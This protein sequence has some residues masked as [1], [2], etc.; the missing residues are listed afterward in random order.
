MSK[1]RAS[2]SSTGSCELQLRPLPDSFTEAASGGEPATKPASLPAKPA[3]SSATTTMR[4]ADYLHFVAD[5]NIQVYVQQHLLL[6]ERLKVRRLHW[7]LHGGCIGG[8]IG[9]CMAVAQRPHS[10][11]T[12]AA[13]R[14]Q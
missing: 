10:G 7:R 3:P 1:R 5:D 14:K 2:L 12:V 6:L 13:W 4:M 9:G 11:C 8:C